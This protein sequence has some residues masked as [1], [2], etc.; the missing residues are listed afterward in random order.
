MRTRGLGPF[1][2]GGVQ[3]TLSAI[4][5]TLSGNS[6]RAGEG[7]VPIGFMI[8]AIPLPVD[9]L[10]PRPADPAPIAPKTKPLVLYILP[11]GPNVNSADVEF[12]RRSLQAFYKVDVRIMP[13]EPLPPSAWYAPRRRHR[14]ELVLDY[15]ETRIPSDG[16]RII[17]LTATDISTTRGNATDWGMLGLADYDRP[18]CVVSSFRCHGPGVSAA[19]ARIRF[20]KISVHEIGHTLGLPHC[21]SDPRCLMSD[22]G[23]SVARCDREDNLCA[24]CRAFLLDSGEPI[25]GEVGFASIMPALDAR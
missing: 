10:S 25:S 23:G 2:A 21:E 11:L 20:G 7:D 13:A 8:A 6:L 16:Y 3:I 24:R 19:K 1:L 12:A 5:L 17:G 15:L 18:V 14:A 22:A 9:S 4:L